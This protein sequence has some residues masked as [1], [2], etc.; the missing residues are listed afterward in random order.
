VHRRYPKQ[1]WLLLIPG[2]FWL[3]FF[4]NAPYIITDLGHLAERPPVPLWYDVG[5]VSMFALTGLF[6]GVHSLRI[7]HGLVRNYVGPFLGWLFVIAVLP[8]GG[9][10]VYLGRFLR[11]NSWDLLVQP[12]GVLSDVALRLANP[13]E[14]PRTLGVSLL[15]A[16]ILL[17][18]YLS[19]HSREPAG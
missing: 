6:L 13:W 19:I 5:T 14:H 9:L 3:V 11:W 15:F 8:L 18:S 10:G 7:M 1:W 16:A 4:P 17:I 12:K 2:A